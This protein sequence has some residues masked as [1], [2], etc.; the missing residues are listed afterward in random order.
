MQVTGARDSGPDNRLH[1]DRL[2]ARLAERALALVLLV[3]VAPL[4][5]TLAL[6]V[7]LFD[8]RPL[9][10][11]GE[12]LGRN[13][14]RFEM[15]KLRTLKVG[16]QAITG[17]ELLGS[18]QDLT[19]RGGRFLRDTRLDEL[20]QLLNIV[21]G[22][23]SF[24]GPRPERP[25]IYTGKCADIPGYEQRFRVRPGLIGISQLFT[26]HGTAKRYRT[27]IDNGSLRRA[28]GFFRALGILAFTMWVMACEVAR[29]FS[30]SLASVRARRRGRYGEK[31]RLRRVTPSNA[32][33]HFGR[34]TAHLVDMS[35]ETIRIQCEE[36]PRLEAESELLLDIRVRG[37]SEPA[38]RT[39]RCRGKVLLRRSSPKGT[40]LVLRYQPSSLRSEYMIHQYFLRGSLAPP[41]RALPLP[42]STPRR[43]LV[44]LAPAAAHL[45]PGPGAPAAAPAPVPAVAP[46]ASP[47]SR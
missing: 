12:R 1:E 7:W 6:A 19:I 16:A 24:V 32:L 40:E 36:E 25:E 37:D 9:L 44:P 21:R 23:M 3:A 13:K 2:P 14:R 46:R 41:R 42:A 22:E 39:A 15:Y 43:A 5:V 20:P 18:R 34:R 26:P 28:P 30:R 8:G 35:E 33:V 47:A 27:L 17:A 11:R 10:Y 29:R 45:S 4:I 31:R 38:H